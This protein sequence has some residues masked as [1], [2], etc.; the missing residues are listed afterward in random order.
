VTST[1]CPSRVGPRPALASDSTRGTE[2]SSARPD[3]KEST[4]RP[5]RTESP[6]AI[7]GFIRHSLIITLIQIVYLDRQMRSPQIG[8]SGVALLSGSRSGSSDMLPQDEVIPLEQAFSPAWLAIAF[9]AP[10]T[11]L[12]PLLSTQIPDSPREMSTLKPSTTPSSP[13]SETAPPLST[14]SRPAS[15]LTHIHFPQHL[16]TQPSYQGSD[17]STPSQ[18]RDASPAR[19]ASFRRSDRLRRSLLSSSE[20]PGQGGLVARLRR[21]RHGE[22]AIWCEMVRTGRSYLFSTTCADLRI[23]REVRV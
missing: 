7:A 1:S 10:T 22:G 15:T 20:D 16:Q 19:S 8:H 13:T 18:S 17:V 5:C 23:S 21:W 9:F 4:E 11:I 3:A 6:K 2:Q 12:P 14:P